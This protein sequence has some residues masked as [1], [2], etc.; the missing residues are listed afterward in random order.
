MSSMTGDVLI[1]TNVFVYTYDARD[2]AKRSR[3]LE[4]LDRLAANG[5]GRISTQ[6]LGE[7]F[8]ALTS[9]LAPRIA[10]AEAVE[11]LALMAS[12]WPVL[13][14]T[15]IVALHAALGVRDHRLAY[16]DAQLWATARLNAIGAILT[17]EATH[18]RVLEG[19]TYLNPF[20][21]AFDLAALG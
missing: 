17:E 2:T 8:R 15:T 10:V 21:A 5:H 11:H 1:D 13:P 18:G 7:I 3:A 19:V 9:R 12:F 14:V 6:V 4:S 20:A 16:W